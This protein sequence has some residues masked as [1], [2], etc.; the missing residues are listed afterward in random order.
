MIIPSPTVEQKQ[1]L[2]NL[3]KSYEYSYDSKFKELKFGETLLMHWEKILSDSKD[4]SL[5]NSGVWEM[6]KWEFHQDFLKVFEESDSNVV[7]NFLRLVK[8]NKVTHGIGYG[9]EC[10]LAFQEKELTNDFIQNIWQQLIV[11]GMSIGA[12]PYYS[13]EQP[14]FVNPYDIPIDELKKRIELVLGFKISASKEFGSFGIE[15][16]GDLIDGRICQ[17]I[18]TAF[19]ITRMFPKEQLSKV[20][21]AEIGAGLGGVSAILSKNYR[22]SVDIYD[23]PIINVLQMANLST[24]VSK[25]VLLNPKNNGQVNVLPYFSFPIR[26]Y[27]LL[28]NRDS[29][30]EMQ[31]EELMRYI[32]KGAEVSSTVLS[33]NQESQNLD[34]TPNNRQHW[35]HI[36]F[37]QSQKWISQIRLPYPF[38]PGYVFEVFNKL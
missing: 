10:W 36:E 27:D 2:Q 38:R 22:I 9:E 24:V 12:I 37:I 21:I 26:K 5:Q 33:I 7:E 16:D 31:H 20:N 23:L 18:F 15:V 6:M 17:D 30:P 14:N 29:F 11:L 32:H 34:G 4:F 19:S 28:L 1:K 3:K 25:D 8:R 13:F 35:T